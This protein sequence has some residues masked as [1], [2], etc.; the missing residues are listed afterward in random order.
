MGMN[1]CVLC[2]LM[3]Q[4]L[5]LQ[6]D[7]QPLLCSRVA[8]VELVQQAPHYLHTNTTHFIQLIQLKY[9]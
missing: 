2:Y 9:R 4:V 6:Q 5:Q 8:A 7:G 3:H 1:G